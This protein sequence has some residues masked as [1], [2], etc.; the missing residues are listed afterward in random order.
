MLREMLEKGVSAVKRTVPTVRDIAEKEAEAAKG[1]VHCMREWVHPTT[2]MKN[3]D[4]ERPLDDLGQNIDDVERQVP[5]D[6]AA[7]PAGEKH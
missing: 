7:P 5:P 6:E 1:A 4:F 2:A 3:P